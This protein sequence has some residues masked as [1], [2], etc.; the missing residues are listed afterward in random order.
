MKK[1]IYDILYSFFIVKR[2]MSEIVDTF[3]NSIVE[4][5]WLTMKNCKTL[6]LHERLS[7]TNLHIEIIKW[8]MD[9]IKHQ[10]L[11]IP[12]SLMKEISN[13][14]HKTLH[15][16]KD[17]IIG[18]MLGL[19]YDIPKTNIQQLFELL[20]HQGAR[21]NKRIIEILEWDYDIAYSEIICK[22]SKESKRSFLCLFCWRKSR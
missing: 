17:G 13:A 11:D 20:I 9:I 1:N 18:L 8:Y 10:T 2:G 6:K 21:T 19:S 14:T 15:M 3:I 4:R 22:S 5:R 7:A 16:S 12:E